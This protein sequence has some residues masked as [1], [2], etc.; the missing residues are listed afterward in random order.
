[1]KQQEKYLIVCLG[2]IA[3]LIIVV[4][5]VAAFGQAKP[6]YESKNA[7]PAVEASTDAPVISPDQKEHWLK[8]QVDYRD[9]EIAVITSQA[10][11]AKTDIE[12]A[13]NATAAAFCK[14]PAGWR[15]D[16]QLIQCVKD[17]KAPD[18]KKP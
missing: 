1:M 18:A 17:A 6:A 10:W 3:L 12:I 7:P 5:N 9:A 15:F 16:A 14:Q 8:L 2:L 11:K 13:I 4:A